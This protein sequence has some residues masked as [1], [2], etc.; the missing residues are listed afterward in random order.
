MEY[1]EER[2]PP[3]RKGDMV[4]LQCKGLG[5]KGDGVFKKDGFMIFAPGASEG[6][7]YELRIT[8]VLPRFGFA[9]VVRAC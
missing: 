3:V 9:E 7:T 2:K 8:R 5:H 1:D 4:K 6:V